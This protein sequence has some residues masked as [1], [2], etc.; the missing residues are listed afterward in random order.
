[1][2]TLTSRPICPTNQKRKK[3]TSK[4]HSSAWKI[5]GINLGWAR[6]GTPPVPASRNPKREESMI[7][8]W[9]WFSRARGK[10]PKAYAEGTGLD[11]ISAQKS[12]KE[13]NI[14]LKEIVDLG[15]SSGKARKK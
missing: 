3:G 13:E 5:T 8:L 14:R 15:I 11:L 1:V 7:K 2:G 12:T 6:T 9:T 10:R 4:N